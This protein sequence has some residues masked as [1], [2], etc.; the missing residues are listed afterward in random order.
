MGPRVPRVKDAGTNLPDE[1][2]MNSLPIAA[3]TS[4][5]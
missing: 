4:K 5:A 3:D 2:S 1:S